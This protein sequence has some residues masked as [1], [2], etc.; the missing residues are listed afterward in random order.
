MATATERLLKE[1]PWCCFC[2]GDERAVTTDHQ[3][4]R[5]FF[6]NKHRPKGFE[7]SACS[8]CN[9]QTSGEEALLAL[10]A[11]MTGNHREGTKPDSGIQKAMAAVNV[12]F[13]NLLSRIATRT[14]VKKGGLMVPVMAID[15]NQ[16]EVETSACR[17]AAKL[18]LATFYRQLGSIVPETALINT[19]WTHNQ[20]PYGSPGVGSILGKLPS[21]DF[22]KQGKDWDTQSTFFVRFH[23]EDGDFYMVAILHESVALLAH[24][25]GDADARPWQ[26][27]YRVW[28]PKRAFGLQPFP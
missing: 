7:F 21:T 2:G 9:R 1:N 28:K 11:R 25:I 16:P 6:P 4:A 8:V 10:I 5:I 23:A 12:A 14:W 22:L 15:A 19:M 26:R 18:A 17:V 13:P 24:V 27:W 20:N 3:P